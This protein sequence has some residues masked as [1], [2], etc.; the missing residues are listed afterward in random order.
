MTGAYVERLHPVA[1]ASIE[2]V[3]KKT[4]TGRKAQYLALNLEA[5]LR[6]AAFINQTKEQ[7]T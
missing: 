7:A 4:L 2:A 5:F 1:S 6:G 3:L